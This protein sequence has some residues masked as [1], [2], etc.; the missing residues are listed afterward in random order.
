LEAIKSRH[1]SVG[2]ARYIGLF[3]ALELVADRKT[4]EILP[5]AIMA[6]L[7]KYLRGKGLFTFIMANNMGSILFIV[8]PLC[9]TREQLDEG[10]A[11]IEEALA[12]TTDKAAA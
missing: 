2:D 8:P 10:L 1:S 11:V 3:S 12:A 5:P 7:G 9:I 4:K 6:D